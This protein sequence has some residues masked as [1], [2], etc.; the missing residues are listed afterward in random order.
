[1]ALYIR[2]S[3]RDMWTQPQ[4]F[5]MI[6][7]CQNVSQSQY[8][9]RGKVHEWTTFGDFKLHVHVRVRLNVYYNTR[10]AASIASLF[11]IF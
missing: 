4:K 1:M 2:S 7:Q 11:L 10:E 9:N 6:C 5:Y 3:I 8:L